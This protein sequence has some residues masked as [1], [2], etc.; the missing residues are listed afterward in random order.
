MYTYIRS[1]LKLFLQE[2]DCLLSKHV[3]SLHSAP[4]SKI[5]S[6]ASNQLLTTVTVRRN[7]SVCFIR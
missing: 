5:A 7:S 2:L 1:S 4:T 6:H 3:M